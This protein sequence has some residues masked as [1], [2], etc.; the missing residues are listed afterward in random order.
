MG[1]G[2]CRGVATTGAPGRRVPLALQRLRP[3]SW[4]APWVL[5]SYKKGELEG[6][7]ISCLMPQ[8]FS[9][10][11][12]SYLKNYITTGGGAGGGP[13]GGGGGGGGRRARWQGGRRVPGLQRLRACAPPA[14][15]TRPP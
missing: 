1:R 13:W 5:C 4:P 6:K 7:N 14:A 10:R 2:V 8:P 15:A 3:A 9:G 12:N 11:H